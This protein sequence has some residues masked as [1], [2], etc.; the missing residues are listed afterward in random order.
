MADT[1]DALFFIGLDVIETA[2]NSVKVLELQNL[3]E[4][5]IF[6]A[7]ELTWNNP[8]FRLYNVVT[9]KY[10]DLVINEPTGSVLEALK[11]HVQSG[12]RMPFPNHGSCDMEK[13]NE[14]VIHM[15]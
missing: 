5:N 13:R 7:T 14:C 15:D 9:K 10:P 11:E 3:F 2:N 8:Y 12:N 4:S 1:P 6:R